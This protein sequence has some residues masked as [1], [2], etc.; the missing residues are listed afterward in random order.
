[1]A[2]RDYYL[3][4]GLGRDKGFLY[5]NK[6]FLICV[7]TWF[8]GCRQ[9]LGNDK[10]FPGRDRVVFIWFSVTT[11]F[12]LCSDNVVT[13]GPLLWLRWPRQEVRVATGAW[14][15]LGKFQVVTENFGVAIGF[16]RGCVATEYF[17]S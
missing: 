6:A 17:M 8:P 14:L 15:R 1:M 13:E 2:Q 16:S 9:L 4:V 7:A 3:L 10:G 11:V 5:L 12:I